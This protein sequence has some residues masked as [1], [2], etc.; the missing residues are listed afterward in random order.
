[1]HY[2]PESA[3]RRNSETRFAQASELREAER[4]FSRNHTEII[5]EAR[6]VSAAIILLKSSL[7][8][9]IY[10]ISASSSSTSLSSLNTITTS[11]SS[12]SLT[13][14][15]CINYIMRI[16]SFHKE[17]LRHIYQQKS[18]NNLVKML[19]DMVPLT[20]KHISMSDCRWKKKMVRDA[21]CKRIS[22]FW[23]SSLNAFRMKWVNESTRYQ[24]KAGIIAA[25]LF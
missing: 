12:T 14:L 19:Q 1:M 3:Q 7:D 15:T 6:L 22:T 25:F 11:S 4:Y 21:S 24:A 16:I 8:D 18:G 5:I 20:T 9:V 13:Q 2:A 23:T 17:W 10:W